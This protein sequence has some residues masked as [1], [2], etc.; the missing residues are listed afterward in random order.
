TDP[1]IDDNLNLYYIIGNTLYKNNE[2]FIKSNSNISYYKVD[3]KG[4]IVYKNEKNDVYFNENILF[5]ETNGKKYFATL[6]NDMNNIINIFYDK[7]EKYQIS[8][9]GNIIDNNKYNYIDY[10]AFYNNG[11]VY[12]IV[13]NNNY[14]Y[15][16]SNGKKILDDSFEG[17]DIFSNN[18]PIITHKDG[19]YTIYTI[20]NGKLNKITINE[21]QKSKEGYNSIY[22]YGDNLIFTKKIE[23]YIEN[24]KLVE[25]NISNINSIKNSNIENKISNINQQ[26]IIKYKK[27]LLLSKLK[28]T[29]LKKE[30]YIKTIDEITKKLSQ[31]K[32]QIIL[33]KIK[34]LQK[35]NE[36]IDYLEAKIYLQINK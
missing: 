8:N 32:G 36:V 5:S 7:N 25:L 22:A 29:K 19:Y 18:K 4:N 1:K 35:R 11:S 27:Q 9:N 10:N 20:N 6:D 12:Y 30:N 24:A 28:L 21:I 16:Y 14:M 26:E 23:G 3:E 2:E 17:I 13:K 33:E 34:N 31:E 15:L